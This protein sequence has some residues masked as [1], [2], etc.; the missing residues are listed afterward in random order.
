MTDNLTPA[1]RFSSAVSILLQHE[2][3]YTHDPEDHGGCTNF[4]IEQRELDLCHAR[5]NL[6]ADVKLLTKQNAEDYYK[7]EWWDKFNYNAVN[8]LYLATKILDLC[9]NVGAFEGTLLIQ[10][11]VNAC[12]HKIAVDGKFGGL[13]IGAIN[14]ISLHNREEDLKFEIQD[15]QKWYYETIVEEH[16]DQKVFLKGWLARASF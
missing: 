2:G 13:T 3:G 6:P 10:R 12:G 11:A 4:G 16:P 5:L 14:E 1:E 7:S 8:S 9:V 15:E